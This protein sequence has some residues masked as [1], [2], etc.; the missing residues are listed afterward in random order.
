MHGDYKTPS[1]IVLTR[2]Q[3]V[4]FDS[5]TRPAGALL[6]TL[7]MIRHVMFVGAS[8]N[9]DNV[10]RLAYEV[11]RYRRQHGLSG[12]VGTLLDVDDDHVRQSLWEDQISWL[13]MA[14]SDVAERSRT[15]EVFLDAVA[16][17]ASSDATWLMDER[18]L[19]LMEADKDL[20]S[21]ARRLYLRADAADGAWRAVA[22][23]LA[24]FGAASGE[25][26]ERSETRRWRSR[27]L[28]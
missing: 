10:I 20:V 11:D 27:R 1:S 14:G 26:D 6:Q 13:T 17:Y 23:A 9:D 28:M 18:F 12:H 19:G 25:Y 5:A 8:F 15:L 21:A 3:F 2:E 24:S 22:D 4:S 16:A 7:L